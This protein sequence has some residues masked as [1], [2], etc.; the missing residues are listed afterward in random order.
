STEKPFCGP[1][2]TA[3]PAV[4]VSDNELDKVAA[5]WSTC[6]WACTSVL[7]RNCRSAAIWPDRIALLAIISILA[8]LPICRVMVPTP[9]LVGSLFHCAL[10]PSAPFGLKVN[11]DA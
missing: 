1:D 4:V 3:V 6:A 5:I 10:A 2:E 8:P 7:S 11:C 9:D